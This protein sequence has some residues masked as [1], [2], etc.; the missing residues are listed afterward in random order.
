MMRISDTGSIAITP[1]TEPGFSPGY[2][3]ILHIKAPADANIMVETNP[4]AAPRTCSL[5]LAN[6]P[7]VGTTTQSLINPIG[8]IIVKGVDGGSVKNL[9][10]ISTFLSN[11]TAASFSA[12]T[13]FG[14]MSISAERLCMELRGNDITSVASGFAPGNYGE[15]VL[16]RPYTKRVG[17]GTYNL[18]EVESGM[19]IWAS[20]ESGDVEFRLPGNAANAI[21]TSAP[22][23]GTHYRFICNFN[24]VAGR[25][26]FIESS[27][28]SAI[29]LRIYGVVAHGG[30]EVNGAPGVNGNAPYRN[31]DASG[32]IGISL[33]FFL[34]VSS[35]NPAVIGDYVDLIFNGESWFANG[36]VAGTTADATNGTIG[37]WT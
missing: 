22:R 8:R 34:G 18:T 15:G 33:G 1:G 24:G 13:L 35:G 11:N 31:T 6:F 5:T 16:Y 30:A 36:I 32:N 17:T 12:D 37:W 21:Q 7:I 23:P 25:I 4:G 26:I 28:P 3:D 19:H 29:D 20:T 10:E 27:D 14:I 2:P 9:S